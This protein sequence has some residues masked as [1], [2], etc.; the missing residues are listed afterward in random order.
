MRYVPIAGHRKNHRSV[1]YMSK[2]Q[3]IDL[4]FA[5]MEGS[6]YLSPVRIEVGTWI[7]NFVASADYFG[8]L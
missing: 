6:R 7:G 4:W 8:K 3:D 5:P 1:E 2:N